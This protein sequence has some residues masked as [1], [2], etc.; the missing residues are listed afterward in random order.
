MHTTY[1]IGVGGVGTWLVP[2]LTRLTPKLKHKLHLFDGDDFEDKNIDRQ[3]FDRSNVGRNKAAVLA[4]MYEGVDYTASYLS[5]GWLDDIDEQDW[6]IVCADNNPAR[7]TALSISDRT[8]ARCI[9]AANEYTDSEAMLYLPEWKDTAEDPRVRYPAILSDD[10]DDPLRVGMGCTGAPAVAS[11][12][13]V[14]A[15]VQAAVFAADLYWFVTQYGT[16]FPQETWP[17]MHKKNQFRYNTLRR[18]N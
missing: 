6:L 17:I 16:E 4:G 5:P 2:M 11:P 3:M 1:I 8:Q 10:S 7:K 15:N 12:Q 9:I 18:N 13:L 14:I